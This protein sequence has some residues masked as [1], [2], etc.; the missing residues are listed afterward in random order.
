M[1]LIFTHFGAYYDANARV[2]G[3]RTGVKTFEVCPCIGHIT[4]VHYADSGQS[5][6][7]LANRNAELDLPPLLWP[8]NCIKLRG[9]VALLSSHTVYIPYCASVPKVVNNDQT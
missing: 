5:I 8:V 7:F 1:G 6:A 3:L 9:H 4:H 2:I